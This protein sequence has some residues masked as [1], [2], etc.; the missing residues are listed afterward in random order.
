MQIQLEKTEGN[1]I[2]AYS[3]GKIQINGQIYCN[4]LLVSQDKLIE[5]IEFANI[6]QIS[7]PSILLHID[8]IQPEIIL[9]G[10]SQTGVFAD[11]KLISELASQ[12]IGFEAMS[13]DAAC[14]TFNILVGE[15]RR[16][17]AYFLFS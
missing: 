10:H 5:S 13:I 3:E 16:V 9:I 2:E 15:S 1:S 14:R 12:G 4:S 6:K 8:E 17:M 7:Y 11:V